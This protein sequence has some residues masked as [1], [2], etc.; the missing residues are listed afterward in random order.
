MGKD[1][2]PAPWAQHFFFSFSINCPKLKTTA[3]MSSLSCGRHERKQKWKDM[4]GK[5]T[6]DTHDMMLW[7][8]LLESLSFSKMQP[9]LWPG[10]V[11]LP[12][13]PLNMYFHTQL[14]PS[15][16]WHAISSFWDNLYKV[17]VALVTVPGTSG[18]AETDLGLVLWFPFSDT[19][20]LGAFSSW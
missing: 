12:C 5:D 20:Q 10:S 16:L 8:I 4:R 7:E 15:R 18:A 17:G 11:A 19:K 6:L 9:S 3:H 1:F 14:I 2:G 13:T